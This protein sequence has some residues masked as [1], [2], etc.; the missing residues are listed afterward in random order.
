M[1]L[2]PIALLFFFLMGVYFEGMGA[3]SLGDRTTFWGFL[4]IGAVHF[5]ILVGIALGKDV[6]RQL[7]VYI[8]LLDLIFGILWMLTSF[9]APSASLSFLAAIA[10]VILTSDELKEEMG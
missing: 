7:G 2:K 10:L 5:L 1:R 3:L 6:I 4:I 9:D 8:S